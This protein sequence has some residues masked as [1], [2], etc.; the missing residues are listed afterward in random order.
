MNWTMPKVG[1]KVK[2]V[3]NGKIVTHNTPRWAY[4][5][6]GLVV[7][8]NDRTATIELLSYYPG[9]R[10]RAD[11][12]D[13]IVDVNQSANGCQNSDPNSDPFGEN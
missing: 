2:I 8:L 3:D 4:G 1:D 11:Y 6:T 10:I 5:E 13:I 9:E 12:A 7:R